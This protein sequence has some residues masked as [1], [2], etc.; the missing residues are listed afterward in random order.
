MSVKLP[1]SLV[2]SSS[3]R[4]KVSD[5]VVFSLARAVVV[6]VRVKISE[7]AANNAAFAVVESVNENV[8]ENETVWPAG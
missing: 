6:S 1:I 3:E 4:L 8:S 2:I 7:I 5:N